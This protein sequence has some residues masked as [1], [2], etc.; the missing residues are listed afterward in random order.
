MREILLGCL[1]VLV[2]LGIRGPQAKPD[3]SG[4]WVLDTVG[5]PPAGVVAN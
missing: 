3:F 5:D 1:S 4:K 2:A